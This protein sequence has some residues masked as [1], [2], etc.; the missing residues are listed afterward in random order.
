MPSSRVLIVFGCVLAAAATPAQPQALPPR[1]TFL[2][3]ARAALTRSQQV[4]HLYSYKERRTDLHLNP[5][6]RMG[7]GGTRVSEVRPSPDPR[8]TYRR[9]IERGGV[10]VPQAELD[11]Q[12]AEYRDRIARIQREDAS[13][14]ER[15]RQD[16]MLARRRAEMIVSDVVDTLQFDLVR[17]DTRNGRPAIVVAFAARPNARPATREGRVARVFKGEVWIDEA[18]REVIDL[19]AVATDDVTFGGFVGKIYEGTQAT[20]ERR[21]IE[22][23]VWMPTRLTLKGDVRALFRKARLDH[24]VEWFDYRRNP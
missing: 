20:V 5:F 21:E 19:A 8:F 3:E 16:E 22:P 9:V 7:T 1:D 15:A 18:S 12:D 24:V 11:R 13:H 10:A 17:R 23:G 4:W 2:S 6:G 14:T